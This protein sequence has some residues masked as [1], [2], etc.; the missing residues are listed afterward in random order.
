SH[1]VYLFFH[2]MLENI[3][4]NITMFRGPFTERKVQEWY[5]EKWFD[6]SFLFYFGRSDELPSQGGITLDSLRSLN[7]IGCPF[8]NFD[9]KIGF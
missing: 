4:I 6:N 3:S 1:Q 5:R 8:V 2:K 7:G 9:E